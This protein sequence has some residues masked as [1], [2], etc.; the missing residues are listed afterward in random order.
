M[1]ATNIERIEWN[2]DGAE[3]L[4]RCN[5]D[6]KIY[7]EKFDEVRSER[8]ERQSTAADKVVEYSRNTM[9][10]GKFRSYE[11]AERLAVG[12]LRLYAESGL[13]AL[14][15][16]ASLLLAARDGSD[17]RVDTSLALS[18]MGMVPDDCAVAAQLRV[19]ELADRALEN[20]AGIKDAAALQAALNA[21]RRQNP[22]LARAAD[23]GVV[24]R[25]AL[26]AMYPQFSHAFK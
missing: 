7:R 13:S 6:L 20:H 9:K 21:V 2:A 15:R 16:L 17:G 3:A 22:A 18:Y 19:Q 23:A 26:I 14:H 10:E 12:S 24:D 11:Q 4:R 5:G 1:S 25:E 8:A